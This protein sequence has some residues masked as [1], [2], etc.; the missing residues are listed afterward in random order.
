MGPREADPGRGH[1]HRLADVV[2]PC[3]LSTDRSC[4]AEGH[5][6]LRCGGPQG[7]RNRHGT[8]ER[9]GVDAGLRSLFQDLA[10]P[11]G[12]VTTQN[13]I[14]SFA[15]R[16]RPTPRSRTQQLVH[17]CGFSGEVVALGG[18]DCDAGGL[19]VQLRGAFEVAAAF[20]QICRDGGV[21]GQIR[22]YPVQRGQAGPRPVGLP[23]R[24]RTVEPHHRAAGEQQ[25]LVVPL[26]DLH[27]SR[28]RQY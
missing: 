22:A 25:Q 5:R 3:G 10:H 27:P 24:H 21:P 7:R 1:G 11:N 4:A 9:A 16:N 6:A 19:G 17:P 23:D 8:A 18:A 13:P 15:K 14:P 2:H 28:S 26:H 12:P 20:V